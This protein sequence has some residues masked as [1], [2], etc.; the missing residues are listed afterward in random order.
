[1]HTPRLRSSRLNW[2]PHRADLNGPVRV[3]GRLN[4][5]S[6]HVP[7]HFKRALHNEVIKGMCCHHLQG[8]END[9][10]DA[11]TT[12]KREVYM[13]RIHVFLQ[14]LISLICHCCIILA[15]WAQKV[16]YFTEQCS[17][18]TLLININNLG[19]LW[20]KLHSTGRELY[21]LA[22]WTRK[23]EEAVK[24]Y[25]WGVA[26]Y[27]D[28]TGTVRAVDQKQL[29]SVEMCCWR[30]MEKI[31]W[32]DRVRNGDVLLR[33]KEQRNIQHEISKRKANWIGHILC[34][35]CLLQRVI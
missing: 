25:I 15:T 24:C 7:S 21:L 16:I 34:R 6:A 13:P 29:E 30:R 14:T 17:I 11:S 10:S 23:W 27:G 2:R 33:V 12:I 1:M 18:I 28:E 9:L 3:A 4:L 35:N 20:L 31:S 8:E 32:T 26:L 22:H 5:V 19:L